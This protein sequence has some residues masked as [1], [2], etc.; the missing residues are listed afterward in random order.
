MNIR[1]GMLR[2]S[3]VFAVLWVAG[4]AAEWHVATGGD[5]AQ[6]TALDECGKIFPALPES[7]VAPNPTPPP[8]SCARKVQPCDPLGQFVSS[9]TP[10]QDSDAVPSPE[11]QGVPHFSSDGKLEVQMLSPLQAPPK[12]P[13]APSIQSYE[14]LPA[15]YHLD[16]PAGSTGDTV[17]PMGVWEAA[18]RK[19]HPGCAPTVGSIALVDFAAMHASEREALRQRSTDAVR[20]STF[21]AIGYG[22]ALSA[23]LLALGLAI[24]WVG[25]GFRSA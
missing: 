8:D 7:A 16:L 1:R 3:L 6:I 10:A 5:R 2:A 13:S 12:D 17:I 14:G 21:A 24:G 9:T 23:G 19:L 15:G 25:R 18:E 22:A 11:T 4:S 20:A